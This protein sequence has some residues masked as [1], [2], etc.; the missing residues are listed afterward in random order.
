MCA[1]RREA[2]HTCGSDS[3]V[4]LQGP[5][6]LFIGNGH[7]HTSLSVPLNSRKFCVDGQASDASTPAFT[8]VDIA[9]KQGLAAALSES[10]G[11]LS[12]SADG[13]GC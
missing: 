6:K 11:S 13:R 2:V 1:R 5:L 12:L 7:G 9:G 3:G 8:A 10:L 4:T